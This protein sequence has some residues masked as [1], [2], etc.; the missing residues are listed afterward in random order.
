MVPPPHSD[1]VSNTPDGKP[2]FLITIDTEGDNHWAKPRTVTTR[3]SRFLPRFQ[4]LCEEFGHKPTYLTDVDMA[5][6]RDFVPFGRDVIA[7]GVG[8]IGMHLHAWNTPPLAPITHDDFEYAPYLIEY[9]EAAMRAKVR[10]MTRLLEDAFGVKMRSHRAGRWAFDAR[11]A[12]MLVEDGYEVD[13]SVTPRVSW[14]SVRGDPAQRGGTDYSRFPDAPY[15]IDLDD[16]SRPGSSPL[17]ELPVTV[18]SFMSPATARLEA[19]LRRAP[20]PLRFPA[21]AAGG[22]LRRLYPPNAWLRPTGRNGKQ[23]RAVADR[24]VA[25]R[26]PYAQFML[27]SSE[28]MAGGSPTF[29]TEADIERLYADLRALFVHADGA[30]R[31]MTLSEYRDAY[32]PARAA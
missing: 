27:H 23:L 18:L 26:R 13:C 8:E 31:P 14:A 20:A 15:W 29:R 7:R 19:G 22:V 21:R 12:R 6:C 17:L 1:R 25:E 11:Y 4:A 28:F 2:A 10:G 32:A 24:V 9:P 30:F 5:Q 16:I 3:N